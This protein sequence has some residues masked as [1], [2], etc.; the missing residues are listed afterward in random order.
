MSDSIPVPPDLA[1]GFHDA[2]L[3]FDSW[4][5]DVAELLVSM[6]GKQYSMTA[7]CGLV[8]GFGTST[9][10][11]PVFDRLLDYMDASHATLK[12]K[13]SKD[14]TYATA[15]ECLRELIIDRK[16]GYEARQASR[17]E[18]GLD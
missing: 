6:D 13:L 8:H 11:E 1:E 9:I 3:L 4:T 14:R 16:K 7:V 2:V 15:A 5:P 10:P 18:H 17:R 12:K